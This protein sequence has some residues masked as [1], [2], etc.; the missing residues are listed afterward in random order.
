MMRLNK[1][2]TSNALSSIKRVSLTFL[3]C[4]LHER[5][6]RETGLGGGGGQG[7]CE[8]RSEV[9]VKYFFLGGGGSGQGD[10]GFGWGVARFGVGGWC[11]VWGM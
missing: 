4:N 8:R 10:Q 9:F 2:E 6:R 3:T 7:G 5:K 11:G 1:Q